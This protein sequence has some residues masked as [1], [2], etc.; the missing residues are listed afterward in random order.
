MAPFLR[1]LV[2]SFTAA[3]ALHSSSLA[4]SQQCEVVG[5]CLDDCCSEGTLWDDPIQYCIPNVDS[6]GFN[7]THVAA[8]YEE[9]CMSR[10]CCDGDCCGDGTRYDTIAECCLPIDTS[11]LEIDFAAASPDN[12]ILL[13]SVHYE[14][15]IPTIVVTAPEEV[16]VFAIQG[17]NIFEDLGQ[18]GER[19]PPPPEGALEV[20]SSPNVLRFP[21]NGKDTIIYVCQRGMVVGR[22]I[23]IYTSS[24]VRETLLSNSCSVYSHAYLLIIYSVCFRQ[25][26]VDVNFS[27]ASVNNFVALQYQFL[28][29]FPH[30]R[31]YGGSLSEDGCSLH[32]ES[33]DSGGGGHFGAASGTSLATRGDSCPPEGSE[34]LQNDVGLTLFLVE[35][36]TVI[37][38][39]QNG[40]VIARCIFRSGPTP[41]PTSVSYCS[42]VVWISYHLVVAYT[43]LLGIP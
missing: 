32:Y 9:G 39:C 40:V 12:I 41:P 21:L 31:G 22:F 43:L 24:P 28:Y 18:G 23:H 4:H 2:W 8:E 13:E 33:A 20:E 34:T 35:G 27:A 7:G 36:E 10:T 15:D 5:C 42:H 25:N 38:A 3:L 16:Q 26:F 17:I 30:G 29:A 1:R 11:T 37:Y 14:G 6:S 19:C